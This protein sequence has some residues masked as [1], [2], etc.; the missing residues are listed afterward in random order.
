[1]YE[2]ILKPK[3]TY[4][5]LVW[6]KATEK[7]T[8]ARSLDHV[9]AVVLR[10]IYG[11]RKST[12][13]AAVR[14]MLDISGLDAEVKLAA[15]RTAYRLQCSK[16][17]RGKGTGHASIQGK[18]LR[19]TIFKAPRDRTIKTTMFGRRF[20]ALIPD[21]EKWKSGQSLGH[22]DIWYTDGSKDLRG[23]GFGIS[24]PRNREFFHKLGK[25]NT[26]F[27]AEVA[28]VKECAR[29]LVREG[30]TGRCIRICTDSQATILALANHTTTSKLVREAKVTL[31][32]LTKNN[33]VI[34]TWI[35]GHSGY[36]GNERADY[37]AKRGVES[38][39]QPESEIGV[40]F[41]EGCNRIEESLREERC[42]LCFFLP[43]SLGDPFL[44]A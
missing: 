21:R 32:E 41:Q 42:V 10:G 24:G 39:S 37:L 29:Y 44:Q 28:A 20:K 13:I 7:Y 43:F 3:L 25:H 40:P 33:S 15:A 35:P 2:A 19:G 36:K 31:N 27:Q 17:W 22:G 23:T 11:L 14:M 34:V 4:A 18:M 5:A 26:I 16:E 38:G 12:P 9:Q 1:L 30:M 8:T 6:W